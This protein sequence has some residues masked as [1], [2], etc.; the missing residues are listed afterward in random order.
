[1]RAAVRGREHARRDAAG[2]IVAGAIAIALAGCGG[3]AA[4]AGEPS[5]SFAMKIAAAT[6]PAQQ[7][8]A[9]PEQMTLSVTNTSGHRIPDLTVSVDSFSYQSN[10]PG[11]AAR[12][13]PVWVIERGPGTP[14][15]TPVESQE[16]SIPGGGQTAYVNTWALGP[17][18]AEATSNLSWRVVPVKSGTYTVHFSFAAG[19]AGRARAHLATGGPASGSFQVHVAGSPAVTHVNPS[20]GKL[21]SGPYTGTP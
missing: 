10:Y 13:R 18:A 20:T 8:I 12:S 2:A 11:L 21:V 9:K 15:K 16:V 5:T 7:S 19:L 4:T 6:F 17:L 14:A 1:M 3:S